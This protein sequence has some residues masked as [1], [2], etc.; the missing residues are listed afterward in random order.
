MDSCNFYL[1]I[2][3]RNGFLDSH[4]I[5]D[6]DID[7]ITRYTSIFTFKYFCVHTSGA[8]VEGAAAVHSLFLAEMGCL[9]SCGCPRQKECPKLCKLTL[10]ITFFLRF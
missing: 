8:D 7:H 4:K 3:A 9:T 1:E 2:F 10:K 5:S 6:H